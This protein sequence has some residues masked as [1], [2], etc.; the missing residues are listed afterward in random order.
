[1]FYIRSE[2]HK[3][4]VKRLPSSNSIVGMY[5]EYIVVYVS[6]ITCSPCTSG[7]YDVRYVQIELT[8][9]YSRLRMIFN[10]TLAIK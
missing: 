2:I 9:K 4:F 5:L 10:P 8:F 3:W 1:M 6:V 7:V